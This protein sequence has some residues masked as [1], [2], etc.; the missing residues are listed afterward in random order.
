MNRITNKRHLNARF[1]FNYMLPFRKGIYIDATMEFLNYK[2]RRNILFEFLSSI[3]LDMRL[4]IAQNNIDF[5]VYSDKIEDRMKKYNGSSLD[6]KIDF[7]DFGD[8]V[9]LLNS[10]FKDTTTN[11][12]LCKDLISDLKKLIQ[13][14][15]LEL[16]K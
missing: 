10:Y 7:L 6:E 5:S 12:K 1:F 16:I 14:H 11:S 4:Y 13:M 2:L 15:V 3:E 9:E 8:Y